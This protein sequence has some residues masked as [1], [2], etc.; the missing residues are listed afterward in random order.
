MMEMHP[1]VIVVDEHKRPVGLVKRREVLKYVASNADAK[2]NG[3]PLTQVRT[4]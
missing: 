2:E 4:T 3:K 1:S